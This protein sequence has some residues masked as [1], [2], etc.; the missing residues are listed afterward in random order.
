[1]MVETRPGYE[2]GVQALISHVPDIIHLVVLM[3]KIWYQFGQQPGSVQDTFRQIEV[4]TDYKTTY[5]LPSK[6]NSQIR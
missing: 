4:D 5:V 3:D 2:G 1:M 6:S